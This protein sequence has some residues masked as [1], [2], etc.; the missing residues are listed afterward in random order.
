LYECFLPVEKLPQDRNATEVEMKFIIAVLRPSRSKLSPGNPALRIAR[1]DQPPTQR[2]QRSNDLH[3]R[4]RSAT[5]A[6]RLVKS[7]AWQTEFQGS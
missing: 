3:P 1:R 7:M 5:A 4:L 6:P 2:N